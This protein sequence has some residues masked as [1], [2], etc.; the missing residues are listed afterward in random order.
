MIR[1]S[2]LS[3]SVVYAQE[4]LQHFGLFWHVYLP[5]YETVEYVAVLVF[6]S[7]ACAYFRQFGMPLRDL[8][9][10]IKVFGRTDLALW[11]TF[12]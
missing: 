3:F 10:P 5:I 11:L 1:T 8:P 7:K 2:R 12:I 6:T 4:S 9:M